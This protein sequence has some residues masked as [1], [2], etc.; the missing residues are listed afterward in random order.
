MTGFVEQPFY[1]GLCPFDAGVAGVDKLAVEALLQ[2]G[3]FLALQAAA[4]RSKLFFPHLLQHVVLFRGRAICL[5]AAAA[6][7]Q[8]TQFSFTT[9]AALRS[10]VNTDPIFLYFIVFTN[11]G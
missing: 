9:V 8:L 11:R 5:E 10:Y 3:L 4:T 2:H 6:T 1:V 7:S